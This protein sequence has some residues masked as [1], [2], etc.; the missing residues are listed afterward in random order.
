MKNAW[1]KS[2][3]SGNEADKRPRIIYADDIPTPLTSRMSGDVDHEADA[4]WPADSVAL[5]SHLNIL[6]TSILL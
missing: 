2:P 3:V 1:R 5:M 6:K 4:D